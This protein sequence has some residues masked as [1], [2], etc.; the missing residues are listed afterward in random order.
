M[1]VIWL[2]QLRAYN[3]LSS[4]TRVGL[5]MGIIAWGAVG[6]YLSDRAEEKYEAPPEDK[7]VVDRYV[8][9]VT[10]VEKDGSGR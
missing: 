5:G 9:R 10:V 4:K 6:L 7:A 1:L 2:T 8:P 3:N